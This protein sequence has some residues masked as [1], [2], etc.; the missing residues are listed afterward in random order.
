M[1]W[2]KVNKDEFEKVQSINPKKGIYLINLSPR[3]Y[4]PIE[5]EEEGVDTQVFSIK[6]D[7]MPN[8]VELKQLLLDLQAAYD[9]GE[10]VNTFNLGE[11]KCWLDKET[12]VG[13]INSITIQKDSGALVTNLWLNG[14][15]YAVSVDYALTFLRKL[16]LYA[17]SCYNVTQLHLSE[18]KQTTNR[19]ALFNYNISA[20]YPTPIEFDNSEIIKI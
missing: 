11:Q 15:P 12:R 3:P 4:S 7:K 14:K 8:T 9:K 13:L 2:L 19:D 1:N 18:I 5:N 17:V 16:E 6:V 20:G 10:E